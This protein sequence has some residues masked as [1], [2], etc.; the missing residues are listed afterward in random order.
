MNT[1]IASLFTIRIRPQMHPTRS[2]RNQLNSIYTLDKAFGAMDQV[3]LLTG[4]VNHELN[5][6]YGRTYLQE[7]PTPQGALELRACSTTDK[8]VAAHD[9]SVIVGHQGSS[10]K[11]TQALFGPSR[12]ARPDL[13]PGAGLVGLIKFSRASP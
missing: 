9:L 11:H 6:K 12:Q 1:L 8:I 7:A 4:C 2:R 10:G 5:L 13:N 3:L